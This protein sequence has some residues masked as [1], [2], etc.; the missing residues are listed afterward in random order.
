M[1]MTLPTIMLNKR[2]AV[3]RTGA[4]RAIDAAKGN[5]IWVNNSAGR[6]K[7]QLQQQQLSQAPL[8]SI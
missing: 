2:G 7:Q 8:P 6:R 5:E 1:T 4:A 3:G